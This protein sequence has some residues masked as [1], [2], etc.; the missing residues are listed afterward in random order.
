MDLNRFAMLFLLVF[1][2]AL[3]L[4]SDPQVGVIQYEIEVNGVL[5]PIV[6]A[7]AD[8]SLKWSVDHL[9]PGPYTFRARVTE[10]GGWWSDFSVPFGATKPRSPSGVRIA[11]N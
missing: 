7:E 2:F 11:G 10:G 5:Q 9:T 1:L 8:G 3:F 4:V 6:A